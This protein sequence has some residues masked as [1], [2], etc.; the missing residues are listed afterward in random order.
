MRLLTSW[1]GTARVSQTRPATHRT[2]LGL[3]ALEDRSVPAVALGNIDLIDGN[4]VVQGWAFDPDSNAVS[5]SV[6]LYMNGQFNGR[7]PTAVFR[8]DVNNAFGIGGTH[9]FQVPIPSGSGTAGRTS[10]V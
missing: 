4:G 10:C 5:A 9:G 8:I 1:L 6:D 3:T 7:F 2:R